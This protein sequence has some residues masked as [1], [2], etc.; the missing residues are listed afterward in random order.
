MPNSTIITHTYQIFPV[1]AVSKA[2]KMARAA[3]NAFRKTHLSQ[4][5]KLVQDLVYEARKMAEK[6][7]SEESLTHQATNVLNKENEGESLAKICSKSN[8]FNPHSIIQHVVEAW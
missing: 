7:A 6:L 8:L 1:F 5:M 3:H 4:P 2:E